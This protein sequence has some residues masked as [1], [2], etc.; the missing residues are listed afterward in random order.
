MHTHAQISFVQN[1]ALWTQQWF[2]EKG[3]PSEQKDWFEGGVTTQH[4]HNL[5]VTLIVNG[6]HPYP[7]LRRYWK[8]DGFAFNDPTV[9]KLWGGSATGYRQVE[10]L[11]KYLRFAPPDDDSDDESDSE[12]D[13]DC[14]PDVFAKVR[15]MTDMLLHACETTF[16]V[17][18]DCSLDEIDINTQCKF[19]GKETIKYKREGDGVLNDAVCTSIEGALITFHFRKDSLQRLR[20]SN[21]DIFAAAKELSPLH[22]RCLGLLNKPCIK[23]KWRTIWMD[24]LFPSLRFFYYGHILTQT[25]MC[26]LFRANRGFPACAWQKV[27]KRASEAK[28]LKGTVKK[29]SLLNGNFGALAISVY[30]NK[31]VHIM[32]TK[33]R[34]SPMQTRERRWFENGRESLRTYQ[35]LLLIHLYNQ[36]MDGVD[37]QDQLRWYYRFDGKKMWRSRKWTWSMFMWVL[38]TAVVQGYIS[39]L[40]LVRRARVKYDRKWGA[41]E[42]RRGQRRGVDVEAERERTKQQS[43]AE[44]EKHSNC[45]RPR[46]LTHIVFRTTLAKSWT[47]SPTASML[48][49]RRR[50]TTPRRRGRPAA[51]IAPNRRL[52]KKP[53]LRKYHVGENKSS[54]MMIQPQHLNIPTLRL[55]AGKGK[56]FSLTSEKSLG[57]FQGG[58][59]IPGIHRL[60]TLKGGR[61]RCQVCRAMGERGSYGP[62]KT[63]EPPRAKLTCM[64]P[65]CGGISLCSVECSNV[66]HIRKD[67]E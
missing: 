44:Y 32:T 34:D 52:S 53:C 6:L 36:F 55:Y 11:K 58:D 15:P 38:A 9:K 64:N 8:L 31:P 33:E 20:N 5:F 47:T 16:D 54:H 49:P 10:L 29:A 26:G 62:N 13:D 42:L 12:S 61:S 27:E 17:G 7:S 57:R 46:P 2:E 19:K 22:L 18:R 25:H 23:G 1:Q 30:D 4:I 45:K 66:W 39:H 67:A 65:I 43:L 14:G 48:S 40:M 59:V 60:Q 21:A 50:S 63:R 41:W 24:N 51:S 35:R 28:R 37:L 3:L 56:K